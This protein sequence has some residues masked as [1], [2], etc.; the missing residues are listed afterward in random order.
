MGQ[1]IGSERGPRSQ[2]GE[3]DQRH[4]GTSSRVAKEAHFL[5][6]T[7]AV[8]FDTCRGDGPGLYLLT[9]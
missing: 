4:N 9:K 6:D 1:S 2:L 7:H 3:G 5:L 8:G